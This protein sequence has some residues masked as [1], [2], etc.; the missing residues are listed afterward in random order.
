[1][2]VTFPYLLLPSALA[3]R[4]RARRRERGDL[5]RGLM[6]GGIGVLVVWALFQG[7]GALFSINTGSLRQLI[8]PNELLGRVVSI[9]RVLAGLAIPVG[10][11]LGG[12]AIQWTGNVALVYGACGVL[13]VIIPICFAFTALGHAER[14]LPQ[15]AVKGEQEAA[16]TLALEG[17]IATT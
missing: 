13:M 9:G 3:T 11:F 10:A 2:N 17:E 6:F 8:V 15:D 1:M 4:N 14:Y 5:T 16:P 12:L 7:A